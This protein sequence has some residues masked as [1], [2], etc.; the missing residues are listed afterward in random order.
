MTTDR[1]PYALADL[2]RCRCLSADAEL[3]QL[4]SEVARLKKRLGDRVRQQAGMADVRPLRTI[5]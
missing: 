2:R 5:R 1:N 4:R 3:A